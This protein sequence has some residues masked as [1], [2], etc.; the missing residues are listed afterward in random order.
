MFTAKLPF[1]REKLNRFTED[2]VVEGNFNPYWQISGALARP[3]SGKIIQNRGFSRK[4]IF[5]EFRG[6]TQT[7]ILQKLNGYSQKIDG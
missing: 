1:N 3:I 5:K 2:Q 6:V 4:M 7:D